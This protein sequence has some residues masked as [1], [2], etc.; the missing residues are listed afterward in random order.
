MS[1][2]RLPEAEDLRS[3]L[4]RLA[5]AH[6]DDADI[7]LEH[8]RSESI[9]LEDERVKHTASDEGFG[10]GCRIVVGE[11]EGL[12][13][14]ASVEPKAIEEAAQAARAI[15]VQGETKQVRLAAARAP[16]RYP[17]VNPAEEAS[18]EER[19]RILEEVDRIARAKD[20]RVKKVFANLSA[21]VKEVLIVRA[22]GRIVR[23]TRPMV[24]LRVSVI[25]EDRGRRESGMAGGGGRFGLR[26]LLESGMHREFAEEAVRVALVNLDA[27]PAPAGMWPVVL[28]PGWPG[29]L[30]H[31]AV[32][33][34]LEADFNRKGVSVFTGRIGE[35]VAAKGVTV[36][37]DGTL[38]LRR[39]SLAVDDEGEPSQR[40]VLIEDGIL[41]GYMCDRKNARLMGM[42]STGNGRRES[43]AHPV[44]PRMTNTFMLAG[45][46]DPKEIVASLDRGLYAVNFSGGQVDITSG[47]FVFTTSEAYWV[48]RGRIQYPVKMATLSGAGHEVLK[49]ISMIGNDLALDPGIGTCGKDGQSVPVGVGMPTVRVDGIVVGGAKA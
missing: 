16:R 46:H 1:A 11:S 6:A 28:G 24:Q 48:E 2:I 30:L 35:R 20:P 14:T 8:Y 42:R 33:H 39:G 38:P 40:T 45:E 43:Y 15:A 10:A 36:V 18:W 26:K 49:R 47:Q 31:E 3:A 7:Y 12:A 37:D 22:D 17:A 32:G 9:A 19:R 41:V 13:A 23:D 29:V 21:G 25:V 5:S 34:G 4:V 27:R 44:L